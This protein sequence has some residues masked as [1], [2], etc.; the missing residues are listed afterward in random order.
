MK[1]ASRVKAPECAAGRG[2]VGAGLVR[3]NL[4]VGMLDLMVS[5]DCNMGAMAP[6]SDQE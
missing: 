5:M 1:R 3:M 6:G 4:T 2:R